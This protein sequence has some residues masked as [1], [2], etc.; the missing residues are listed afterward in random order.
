MLRKSGRSADSLMA[1]L[2]LHRD[3]HISQSPIS[4]SQLLVVAY[5]ITHFVQRT[6]AHTVWRSLIS[7]F[8]K[9]RWQVRTR[10]GKLRRGLTTTWRKRSPEKCSSG[11]KNRLLAKVVAVV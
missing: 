11:E 9:T 2:G 7:T 8:A 1:P 4:V 3:L 6:V 10:E 5:L